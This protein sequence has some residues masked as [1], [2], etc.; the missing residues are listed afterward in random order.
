MA[1]AEN[2]SVSTS[3]KKADT[4][5]DTNVV[6]G[7]LNDFRNDQNNMSYWLPC[8][9]P[10]KREVRKLRIPNTVIIQVPDEVCQS[11]L[12]ERCGDR[13][14]IIKFVQDEVMPKAKEFNIYPNI[15]MKNGSF[16]DKYRFSLCIP[17]ADALNMA[18]NLISINY[19]AICFNANGI[20]EVC[21]RELIPFNR[22]QIPTIYGGMPLRPEFRVFYD[23]DSHQ[24]LYVVN[25]W[26][27][28]YCHEAV[29]RNFTDKIVY[30]TWYP[31]L[32]EEYNKHKDSVMEMVAAD[33][34]NV[35]GLKGVWSVDVLLCEQQKYEHEKEGFWLIDMAI[36]CK[37]AYW[38]PEKILS[39]SRGFIRE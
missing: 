2:T 10:D 18:L 20:T 4:G 38:D 24:P 34:Q 36:G 37:S 3:K 1:Y 12:L 21:L 15:F 29:C 16:S 7:I 32:L 14:R 25:Y 39:H 22:S 17:G 8:I 5:L 6:C 26:D 28:E 23:F 13:D 11:F 27:W 35:T 31:Q 9:I 33:M 19:D 30:E